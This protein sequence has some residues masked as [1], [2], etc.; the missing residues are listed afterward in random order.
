VRLVFEDG[1]TNAEVAVVGGGL[2]VQVGGVTV[3]AGFNPSSVTLETAEAD[4]NAGSQA[5]NRVI[6]SGSE[7]VLRL[8]FDTSVTG[9]Q[10][11][12][13]VCVG[14]G[15]EV[16]FPANT[17]DRVEFADS[18]GSYT[19]TQAGASLVVEAS[20]GTRAEVA[21]NQPITFAFADGSTTAEI[22]VTG[23]GLGID[24]GGEIVGVGFDPT[25]V[26]L[27]A[28]DP[29]KFGGEGLPP[30]SQAE[31]SAGTSGSDNIDADQPGTTLSGGGGDDRFIFD[32]VAGNTA[33]PITIDDFANGEQLRFEGGFQVS[34]LTVSNTSLGDG[35]LDLNIGGTTLTL[36]NLD[37]ALEGV[38]F[39]ASSFEN[40]FDG[41]TDPSTN[42]GSVDALFFA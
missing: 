18:L 33:G 34:D 21:L 36:T 7:Q 10:A 20:D 9:T 4:P 12:E 1:A 8:D 42:D 31:T 6:L 16:V 26:M 25:A 39:N 14:P 23:G 35:I 19:F 40:A 17:G 15:S 24:L 2:A 30:V 3:D 29:S 32:N 38:V 22:V 41:G 13:T 28:S 5:G 11:A 37:P 27:D